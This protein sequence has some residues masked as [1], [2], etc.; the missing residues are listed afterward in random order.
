[1]DVAVAHQKT[2]SLL[3]QRNIL[4][5]AA[6]GLLV[7]TLWQFVALSSKDERYIL[8]PS[9]SSP[10]AISSS[11]VSRE[12]L[13]LVTRDVAN[14]ILNRSPSGLDYWSEEILRVVHPS[15]YGRMKSELLKLVTD[16][17]GSSVSQ[18]FSPLSYEVNPAALT[19]TVVGELRTYV[20]QQ[21][22]SRA[23][24][25]WVIRWDY[26]GLKLS[27][28]SFDQVVDPISAEGEAR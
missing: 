23:K 25:S 14:L 27:M 17:R 9:V 18:A 12:Y 8:V 20:G 11:A 28:L 5:V 19:S 22:V 2:Q 13:E 3:R 24:H 21:E 4:A 26:T 7:T 16:L 10:V 6:L 1:M 15:A